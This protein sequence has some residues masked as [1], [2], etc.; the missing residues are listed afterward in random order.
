MIRFLIRKPI[1]VLM[2]T[3][4]VVILGLIAWNYIPVSLMPDT[5]IPEIS[6]QLNADMSAREIEDVVV[7]PMRNSLLQ[8]SHLE[9]MES[10]AYNGNA[11]IRMTF[12]H[13]TKIDYSFIEVNEK[14]DK[15]MVSMPRGMERPRVLK[16]NAS[17][18][19]VFYLSLTLKNDYAL[20]E[21]GEISQTFIDFNRFANQVIRKRIE[22]LPEIAMVDVNGIVKPEILIVPDPSQ[23]RALG[24][25]LNDLETALNK[26]DIEIGSILI[27]DSQYQYNL[28][29]GFSLDN[30]RDIGNV[31]LNIK[32]RLFQLKELA[33]IKEQP[34]KRRGLSLFNDKEAISMAIV[35]QSDVRMSD[36]KEALTSSVAHMEKDYA[37]IDFSIG[38]DQ[39]KLLQE[40]IGNL[41]RGL[42]WSVGLGFLIMFFFL[43]DFRS[44]LLIGMSVPLSLIISLLL[45]YLVDISINIISLSGLI[46][47]TGLMIDNSI[48]VIENITQYRQRGVSLSSACIKGTNEVFTPLLSSVL[49]TCAVFVPLIFLSGMAG[50]LFYDQAMAITIGL[51]VSLLVSVTLLPV[52]Y[53]LLFRK[54]KKNMRVDLFLQRLNALDYASLYEKGFRFTMRR[55]PVVGGLFIV[56]LL[57]TISLLFILP[58]RQI[59]K[60][61]STEKIYTI[62]WNEPL[63]VEENKKRVLKLTQILKV[64][65]ENYNAQVGEQQFLMNQQT[66]TKTSEVEVYVQAHSSGQLEKIHDKTIEFLKNYP[67]AVLQTAEVDDVFNMI[68]TSDKAPITARFQPIGKTNDPNGRLGNLWESLQKTFP[69]TEIQPISWEEQ[70]RLKADPAKM[71]L[72]GVSPAQLSTTLVNAFNEQQVL[73]IV[74][75]QNFVPV[76]LGAEE[77]TID[78]VLNHTL[79][80]TNDSIYYKVNNFLTQQKTKALKRITAGKEGEFFPVDFESNSID[81]E[82]VLHKIKNL[83]KGSSEFDVRFTGNYFESRALLKELVFILGI[84]LALL[85]FILATQFESLSLPLII[86]LEIPISI[87]GTFLALWIF[88]MSLNL[89]SMIGVV[90]MSGIVINDSILKVD[91]VIQLQKR[92]FGL[93]KALLVAGQRRVKPILMTSLTTILALIPILF[94]SGLGSELQ[95]PLAVALIA[96]MIF[97]TVVSLYFIPLLYYKL[98]KN[99]R[100]V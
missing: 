79:V 65:L 38:R 16:A 14:I 53:H 10:E 56:F 45:F 70:V 8:I 51:M 96:G 4:A 74:D 23:L 49:T 2:T 64:D 80:R 72:Y 63:S 44:P 73:T 26:Q 99:N 11:V 87:A 12:E 91:T 66:Q 61:T 68:F 82:N 41:G 27:K 36:L 1:A 90:V 86:L 71:E 100:D 75:N 76:I 42:S 25:S 88:G 62:D 59:P 37:D 34:Q 98:K 83:V 55:Q 77:K 93:L 5:D 31:Y 95:T 69:E 18:L 89:M 46:L 47:G 9:D 24:L 84:T 19:P 32:G 58:K 60:L 13:G 22:Q 17:D 6:V 33:K 81:E 43:K 85:Y 39:T 21:N 92:G 20:K 3:L 54:A 50:A 29:L 30:I 67:K 57:T 15:A 94:T 28:R 40:S 78:Q 52:L 35:K 97:G 48:I 7:R